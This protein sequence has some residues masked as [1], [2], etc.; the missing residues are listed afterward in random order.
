[1]L[2]LDI[3]FP[4]SL[5]QGLAMSVIITLQ[6][7]IVYQLPVSHFTF[8]TFVLLRFT[9]EGNKAQRGQVFKQRSLVKED[10]NIS[11]LILSTEALAHGFVWS[12]AELSSWFRKQSFTLTET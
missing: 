2:G 9:D 8:I 5:S 3:S 4:A 6:C 10:P 11:L 12:Y 7:F 1:M